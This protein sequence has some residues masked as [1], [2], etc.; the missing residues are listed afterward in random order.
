VP[1]NTLS[2]IVNNTALQRLLED[3]AAAWWV[4]CV[5]LR[6]EAR[7]RGIGAE[8]LKA[9]VDHARVHG[10]TVVDGHPVD[11][12]RLKANPSPAALFTGTL[13][14]FT[15]A[16]FHELGR[17]YPSRPVMRRVVVGWT[18]P[19]EALPASGERPARGLDRTPAW[20]EHGRTEVIRILADLHVADIPVLCS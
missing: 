11:K 2:G 8:L 10:A 19:A 13:S 15:A 9:A 17:A 5:N 20:D 14:M 4:T 18:S 3:D 16:G 6:R 12:D 1:R 7:G